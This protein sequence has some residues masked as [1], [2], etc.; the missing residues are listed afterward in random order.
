MG[1]SHSKDHDLA[2][3]GASALDESSILASLEFIKKG[4]LGDYIRG[5]A[6]RPRMSHSD[7]IEYRR[8]VSKLEKLL[9]N[10]TRKMDA[11]L[12]PAPDG[13]TPNAAPRMTSAPT[14]ATETDPDDD[15][16]MWGAHAYGL[17]TRRGGL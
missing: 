9:R 1:A 15:P 8:L 14:G 16:T 3:G 13:P 2:T 5:R 6:S 10:L 4:V 17:Y 12:D 7:K 11:S